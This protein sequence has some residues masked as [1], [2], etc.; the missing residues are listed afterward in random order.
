MV[1]FTFAQQS[2]RAFSEVRELGLTPGHVKALMVLN[3]QPRPMGSLAE[4][5]G[6]DA[7]TVTWLVDRLEERGLAERRPSLTDRRVKAVLLTSAGMESRAHLME[8]LYE[9]PDELIALDRSRLEALRSA[10]GHLPKPADLSP[11]AAA[12]S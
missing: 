3:D 4:S 10:L 5:L 2:R 7:S 8:R 11:P 1:Q 12:R 9:P 6:C